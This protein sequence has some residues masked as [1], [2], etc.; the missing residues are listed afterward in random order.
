MFVV[1]RN[2]QLYN[3]IIFQFYLMLKKE[4]TGKLIFDLEF[5]LSLFARQEEYHIFKC[6]MGRWNSL[7]VKKLIV[8]NIYLKK[9]VC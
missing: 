5:S 4:I 7:I 2:G 9:A 8:L 1:G 6:L 3:E